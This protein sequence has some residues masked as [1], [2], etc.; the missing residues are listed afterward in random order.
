[1]NKLIVTIA[2][3]PVWTRR[4]A[5]RDVHWLAFN[6]IVPSRLV[7]KLKDRCMW[8]LDFLVSLQTQLRL[9][10]KQCKV[11]SKESRGPDPLVSRQQQPARRWSWSLG[12]SRGGIKSLCIS[13]AP[14]WSTLVSTSQRARTRWCILTLQWER[15]GREPF[16][17]DAWGNSRFPLKSTRTRTAMRS[18][19]RA[20][21]LRPLGS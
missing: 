16:T 20:S 21:N 4:G 6:T 11:L 2:Q 18:W 13:M 7:T 1:M 5:V 12:R 14:R 15:Q 9:D 17:S 10:W 8:I 3:Y 19:G